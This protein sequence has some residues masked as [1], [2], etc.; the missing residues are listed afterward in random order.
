[1]NR[2]RAFLQAQFQAVQSLGWLCKT[3]ENL[4]HLGYDGEHGCVECWGAGGG[5]AFPL[6]LTFVCYLLSP[7][8]C[9]QCGWFYKM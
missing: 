7:P 1:M 4:G 2:R 9:H 8:A 5:G 6:W 3:L